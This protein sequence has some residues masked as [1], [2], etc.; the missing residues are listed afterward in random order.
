MACKTIDQIEVTSQRVLMRVD[1]NVPLDDEGKI[2][3]HRRIG[4]SM[5][6]IQSVL[7]R[8]GK[9]ILMSPRGRP[10]GTGYEPDY[11][12]KPAVNRLRELLP[13]VKITFV[14]KDCVGDEAKKAVE[15]M[16]DGEIVILDNLRFHEEER[17]G[18]AKFAA[19]LASYGDIYCNEAFGTSHREDASM[20]AVPKAMEGKPRVA[21]L[22]LRKELRYLSETISNAER[23]F[24]A[25][26]G[27]VKVSDKL[28]A[29]RAL[30][31]RVDSILVGG[32]M[33][34]T[35]IKALGHEV[36]SSL[37]QLGMLKQAEQ[38]IEEA[39]E[40]DT[41]L[42]LPVDHVCGKQIS[43]QT[44]VKVF[45][46]SI[47]PGWMGLDIGP[48]TVNQFTE[49]I[50]L[51]RTI[52]WNGPLGVF[53][54]EPFEVGTHRI[55][56]AIVTATERGAISVVGGGDS[57]AAVDHFRMVDRFSHVSTGGGASLQMLEGTRFATVDLLD[58]A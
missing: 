21:G 6:S 35:F 12:L 32:A 41:R 54:T 15:S 22:L 20:F 33:A 23:P 28:G 43:K 45:K 11:S 16:Q 25:V 10:E 26:L 7:D 53:E 34:Y 29:I 1:F 5:P 9:L 27:G 42:F 58:R 40:R 3:D 36:G 18:D 46:E 37:V 38:I 17:K 30:L 19:R 8:K 50:R 57:A 39:A 47:E 51:A 48:E 52:V 4:H 14:E 2:T 49:Q 55:A 56:E 13:E 31:D 44:P 24:V